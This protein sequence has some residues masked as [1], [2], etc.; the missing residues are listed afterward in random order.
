MVTNIFIIWKIFSIICII[1][2]IDLRPKTIF[3]DID[4]ILLNHVGGAIEQSNIGKHEIL[5]NTKETIDK[6]D[7]FRLKYKYKRENTKENDYK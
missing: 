6:S 2:Y 3:Y 4:G 1:C 7:V 5:P